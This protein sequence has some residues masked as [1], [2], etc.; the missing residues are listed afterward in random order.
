MKGTMKDTMG[1]GV[2]IK[3]NKEDLGQRRINPVKRDK[4]MVDCFLC[5]F[6]E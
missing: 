5:V 1:K 2:C 6:L 3:V 4:V